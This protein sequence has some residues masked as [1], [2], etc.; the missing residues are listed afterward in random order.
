MCTSDVAVKFNFALEEIVKSVPSPSIFSPSS[1][2]VKP[3]D[4][5]RLTSPPAP[6]VIVKSVPSD[7]IFSAVANVSPTSAGMFTSVVAVRSMSLPEEIV[8]LV[9]LPSIFSPSSPNVKPKL[10]PMLTSP[11]A[12]GANVMSPDDAVIVLP[13]TLRLS[14][15]RLVNPLTAASNA[16]VSTSPDADVVMLAPPAIFKSSLAIVTETA[17]VSYTHLTLPTIYSV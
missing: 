2:N 6:T 13:L 4:A 11:D 14:T 1:P 10:A 3:I 17:P 7:S 15:V 9:P 8:N 5:P 16:T 12:A